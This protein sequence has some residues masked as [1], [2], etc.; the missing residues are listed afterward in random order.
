MLKGNMLS[1][2]KY[3]AL[4]TA[5]S[6]IVRTQKNRVASEFIFAVV[7]LLLAPILSV[8]SECVLCMFVEKTIFCRFSFWTKTAW[9]EILR[10][11]L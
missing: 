6:N 1:K 10:G 4:G 5:P 8:Y 2:I 3:G 9:S 11:L 7:A